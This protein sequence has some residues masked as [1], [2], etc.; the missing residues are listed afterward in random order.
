MEYRAILVKLV[1]DDVKVSSESAVVSAEYRIGTEVC[2]LEKPSVLGRGKK[3]HVSHIMKFTPSCT[4]KA[5][6]LA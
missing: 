6:L 2:I 3:R 1:S 5:E 4:L